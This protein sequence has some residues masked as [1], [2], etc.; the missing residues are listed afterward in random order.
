MRSLY[1]VAPRR[2][3]VREEPLAAPA[4]G[5][6][7][8]E[9]LVSAI[10][11]GTEMLVYRGQIPR[12]IPLDATLP[13]LAGEVSYPLRYGYAAVGRVAELGTGVDAAWRE[14]LVVSFHPH[15]S[16]FLAAP[17]AL[18]PVPAGLPP[19]DAAFLP[20]VETAVGF[21]M[22]GQPLVGE[23]VVVFGQGVVGLLTAALLVRL[24]LASLVTVDPYALRR[25]RSLALGAGA[26]V[27]PNE[28]AALAGLRASADLT[29]E[30]SGNPSALDQAIAATGFDGRVVVGSWY[31]DRPATLEL[32]GAFHR[33]RIRLL[34]SQVSTIAPRFA[35]RW[36]KARRL[37]VA[38]RLLPA[39]APA[40]LVTHRVPF[41]AAADAYALLDERPE[42][43]V[44]VLLT[45][46]S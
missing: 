28:P 6:V 14:R 27:D 42:E 19:E 31:G 23:R 15:A 13:A 30:V 32:G 17:E 36:S 10:S 5:E 1:F 25:R 46:A 16:H 8:V 34:S 3:E 21:L 4:A 26:A 43:A 9:T 40:R 7:L 29:Y 12:G 41:A 38:W 39:L 45:Y 37:E 11:P 22:D 35:G 18:I 44:Q 33:S 24:P 2:V 20:N